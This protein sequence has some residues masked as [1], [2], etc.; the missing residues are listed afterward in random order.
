M[1][2]PNSGTSYFKEGLVEFKPGVGK[3]LIAH[4]LPMFI[5]QVFKTVRP[6]DTFEGNWHIDMMCEYLLAC[7]R[8]DIKRMIVNIAPRSLK[9][10]IISVAFPAWLLGQDP[11]LQILCASYSRDLSFVHSDNCRKVMESDWYRAIFPNTVLA[12]GQNNKSKFNTTM[13][14]YRF[15]TSVGGTI[16]GVGGDYVLL[17]D[18]ISAKEAESEVKRIN[19]TRWFDLALYS[20]LNHK[21]LSRIV[22]IEQRLHS[23][24]LTGHLLKQGGW[25][26]WRVPTVSEIDEIIECGNFKYYRKE[27]ELLQASRMGWDEVEEQKAKSNYVWAGQYQQRP[28]PEGGGEFRKEWICYYEKINHHVLNNYILVDPANETKKTSDYTVMVVIGLSKDGNWYLVDMIRDKLN[29][30]ERQEKLFMLHEKYKPINVG[31]QKYGAEADIDHMK[32]MM[33]RLTYN[34][35]I[36]PVSNHL[37]KEDRIRRLIPRFLDGKIFM[38]KFLWKADYQNK[39]IDI[40]D[41]FIHEEYLTFPVGNHDDMLDAMATMCDLTP[42]YPGKHNEIDYNNLYPVE[43][44]G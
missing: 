42:V 17:D 10:I 20:R 37:K 35:R 38:P 3:Y 14:G 13:G 22:V 19:A 18:T 28:A 31:Y 9:S 25:F 29:L 32:I 7:Y 4:D 34:F 24:D 23:N 33:D 36:K 12:R 21:K 16:T 15:S 27:G 39:S 41:S 26:H 2:N 30:A 1:K 11:R 6:G 8:G 5:E 43:T 44:R 40:M